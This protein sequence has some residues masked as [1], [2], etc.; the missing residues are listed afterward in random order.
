VESTPARF[1]IPKGFGLSADEQYTAWL[2]FPH[3]RAQSRF[4]ASKAAAVHFAIAANKTPNLRPF[5][6]GVG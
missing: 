2:H 6:L 4:T 3:V 5:G 1:L